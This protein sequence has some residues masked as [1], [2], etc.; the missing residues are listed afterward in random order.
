M[1]MLVPSLFLRKR[2]RER[3]VQ[4][5]RKATCD[6]IY[7]LYLDPTLPA[8]KTRSGVY[9]GHDISGN[10]SIDVGKRKAIFLLQVPQRMLS[11]EEKHL[12]KL[13]HHH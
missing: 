13:A 8:A 1:Y 11:R 2:T 6:W 4:T 9:F 5:D 10:K 7:S 12:E 3:I